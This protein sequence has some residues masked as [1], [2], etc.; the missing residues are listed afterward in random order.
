MTFNPSTAIKNRKGEKG[1]PCL[2]PRSN[3]NSYVGLPL[4]RTEAVGLKFEF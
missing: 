4:T 3:L 1:S 2:N